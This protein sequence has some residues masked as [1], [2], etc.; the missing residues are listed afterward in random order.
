MS[1][2]FRFWPFKQAVNC[3][4]SSLKMK[5][6][7]LVFV[8][9]VL[10]SG[11]SSWVYKYDINQGNFLNQRDVDKLRV[12]M[13]KEQVKFVLGTPVVS[14]PFSDDTWRYIYTIR[15]G[16]TDEFIKKELVL[17]FEGDALKTMTGDF[18]QPEAFMTPL[19]AE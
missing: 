5:H 15:V 9:L 6:L 17:S 7:L 10:V 14:S 13:T 18:E 8:S 11:C 12:E 3:L 16:K 4:L 2:L 19:D 1:E